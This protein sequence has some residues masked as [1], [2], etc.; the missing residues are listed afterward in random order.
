MQS[1]LKHRKHQIQDLLPESFKTASF[2][3]ILKQLRIGNMKHVHTGYTKRI[4]KKYDLFEY[5]YLRITDKLN[6]M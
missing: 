1:K 3:E 6:N 2:F 5:N 4:L